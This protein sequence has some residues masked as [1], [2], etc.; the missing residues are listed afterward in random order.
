MAISV[1]ALAPTTAP[2]VPKSTFRDRAAANPNLTESKSEFSDP[3][4]LS[5]PI[6]MS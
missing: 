6:T 4:Y 3:A 1:D 2:V 5:F